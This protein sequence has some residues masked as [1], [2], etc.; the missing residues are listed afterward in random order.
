MPAVLDSL[1]MDS[2]EG[3]ITMSSP[4]SESLRFMTLW[5]KGSTIS[6]EAS[7]SIPSLYSVAT[8]AEVFWS[9]SVTLMGKGFSTVGLAFD[10]TVLWQSVNP[11]PSNCSCPG[12][13]ADELQRGVCWEKLSKGAG[14]SDGGVGSSSGGIRVEGNMGRGWPTSSSTRGSESEASLGVCPTPSGRGSDDG[15]G[16][17]VEDVGCAWG[18]WRP[19][20]AAMAQEAERGESGG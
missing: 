15:D 6:T 16:W 18:G 10:I 20:E 19:E 9:S 17:L 2:R 13:D 1:L 14:F 4:L 7:L 5:L 3:S 12:A 11:S 8:Q